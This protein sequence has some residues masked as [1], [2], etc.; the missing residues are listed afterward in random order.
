[1][2][3][4]SKI[5]IWCFCV[6]F[7]LRL[8]G[9][10]DFVIN[11]I[12]FFFFEENVVILFHWIKSKDPKHVWNLRD[13]LEL[14]ICCTKGIIWNLKLSIICVAEMAN[15][16]KAFMVNLLFDFQPSILNRWLVRN[17]C[18]LV[19]LGKQFCSMPNGIY[20]IYDISIIHA[21]IDPIHSWPALFFSAALR[22]Q[23]SNN[24]LLS[25]L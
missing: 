13:H 16:F 3:Y 22:Q 14:R 15:Q 23:I 10:L 17:Q 5:T 19:W 6:H 1:M 4:P 25:Q 11:I 2:S 7:F 9:L 21:W 20:A 12:F 8:V 18:F 24:I